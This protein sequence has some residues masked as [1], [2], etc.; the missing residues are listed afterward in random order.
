LFHRLW[1]ESI[2]PWLA[3]QPEPIIVYNFPPSLA[4]LSRLTADGWADRL[5]F[6]WRGLEIGNAFF[7]LNDPAEQRRRFAA[8]AVEKERL[9]RSPVAVDDDF[10]SA[11]EAGMPPACGIAVGLERLFMAAQGVAT[12]QEIKAFPYGHS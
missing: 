4:A 6:Y 8:D 12:I 2:D 5:E 9:G 1:I 7:E 10:L 11:L 3:E